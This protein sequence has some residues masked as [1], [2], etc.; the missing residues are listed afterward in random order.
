MDGGRHVSGE[1][2]DSHKPFESDLELTANITGV[3]YSSGWICRWRACKCCCASLLSAAV[4]SCSV[5]NV[6]HLLQCR[7]C[8]LSL[9]IVA[10]LIIVYVLLLPACRH[11]HSGEAK[12]HASAIDGAP[13][14]RGSAASLL[15]H[16]QAAA[17]AA[18]SACAGLTLCAVSY[19]CSSIAAVDQTW[20]YALQFLLLG[21]QFMSLTQGCCA[22]LAAA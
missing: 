18:S 20:R 15:Q 9:R 10:S 7:R 14:A 2:Y 1:I 19:Q 12:Q 8:M 22:A 3:M 21:M 11:G 13:A 5:Y 16:C 17:A 6:A 4:D